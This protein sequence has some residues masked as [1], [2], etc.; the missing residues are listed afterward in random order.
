[1]SVFSVQPRA[2]RLFFVVAVAVVP[3]A[4]SALSGPPLTTYELSVPPTIAKAKS[5]SGVQIL[6]P[7]PTA[8]QMVDSD[9]IVVN[10][11]SRVSYYPGVQWPDRLPKVLQN[12][13]I[14]A[15]EQSGRARAVGRPGEGLSVDY[16]VLTDIRAFA[17]D[18]S[19]DSA[20]VEIFAKILNDRTGKVVG[21]QLFTA[22]VPLSQDS[23]EA[24]VAGLDQALQSVLGEMV[25]WSQTR[26]P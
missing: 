14:T 24:V 20:D 7:E 26:F 12:K 19:T 9:R 13:L 1:V 6:V 3:A 15:F 8:M 22:T 25:G 5:T 21:S 2:V 18:A 4:C 17:Y 10:T 23:A 16:Q 11:G